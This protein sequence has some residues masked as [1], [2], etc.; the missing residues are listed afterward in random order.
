MGMTTT[1]IPSTHPTAPTDADD[2]AGAFAERL[3]GAALGA[4]DMFTTYLG[5]R[6]GLYQ[7]LADHP[8][9]RRVRSLAGP[10]SPRVTHGSG[11]SSRR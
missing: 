7:D 2:V 5:L 11:W 1:T 6:L 8:G 4:I 9:R 10:A 3:F